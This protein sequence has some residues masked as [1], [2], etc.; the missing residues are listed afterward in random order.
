VT[1]C[2]H[3]LTRIVLVPFALGDKWVHQPAGAAFSDGT[4]EFCRATVAE[5]PPAAIQPTVSYQTE[6]GDLMNRK[7]A[8]LATTTHD[9][10]NP[11]AH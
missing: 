10:E 6:E 11:D 4:Y 1:D 9:E 3:C 7:R 2:R 5:P 8:A